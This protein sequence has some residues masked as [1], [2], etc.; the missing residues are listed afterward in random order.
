MTS[1]D[2]EKA[3]TA[4]CKKAGHTVGHLSDPGAF[5]HLVYEQARFHLSHLVGKD[6]V[7]GVT[8]FHDPALYELAL[9]Q[10]DREIKKAVAEA[11]RR[12]A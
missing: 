6:A 8:A 7:H 2:L 10:L 9:N 1:E 12:H 5:S 4:I 11:E 3:I